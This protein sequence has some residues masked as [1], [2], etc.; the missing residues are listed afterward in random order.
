[1][2]IKCE[3][4]GRVCELPDFLI[5]YFTNSPILYS[6]TIT[7][8]KRPHVQPTIFINEPGKCSIVLLANNQSL[9]VQN[10]IQNTHISLTIDKVHPLN[11]FLNKGIMIEATSQIIDS[12]DAIEEI[13]KNFERKYTSEVVSKILG[14]DIVNQ[15]V[16]IRSL[17][18]KIVYW[19]GPTFRRFRCRKRK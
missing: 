7:E 2:K 17:P 5:E 14:I 16:K 18:Q 6:S 12:K 9:M 1:M 13:V 10:L 3:L 11:P 19:E 4:D 8:N 15:S